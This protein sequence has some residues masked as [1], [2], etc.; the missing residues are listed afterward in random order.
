MN[1]ASLKSM[2]T[3]KNLWL[4]FCLHF[5]LSAFFVTNK[6]LQITWPSIKLGR[7]LCQKWLGMEKYITD[8]KTVTCRCE[9][10]LSMGGEKVSL[11]IRNINHIKKR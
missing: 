11:I 3:I 1:N 4:S 8:K 9:E 7:K 10:T 2:E 6:Y 5:F